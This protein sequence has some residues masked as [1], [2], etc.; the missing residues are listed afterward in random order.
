MGLRPWVGIKIEYGRVETN[1]ET[2]PLQYVMVVLT[3]VC[4]CPK[5]GER[6]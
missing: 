3:A 6:I 2:A 4:V 1:F 5:Y